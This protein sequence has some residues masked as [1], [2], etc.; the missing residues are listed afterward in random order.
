MILTGGFALW[1]VAVGARY[2]WERRNGT[3]A[4]LSIE[5]AHLFL[6]VLASTYVVFAFD[7]STARPQFSAGSPDSLPGL[8]ID[9]QAYFVLVFVYL[10]LFI[11]WYGSE[12]GRLI[13][14]ALAV[15]VL[16]LSLMFEAFLY[17]PAA[18]PPLALM[19]V[20]LALMRALPWDGEARPVERSI[21]W[22]AAPLLVFSAVALLST[23]LGAFPY[24]SLMVT[25]KMSTMAFVAV[26]VFDTV[27]E[28]RQRWLIW[29]AMTAPT[30]TQAA[31][32]TFKVLD[33]ARVMGLPYAFG[34]RIELA[35]GVDPNPL[36][37]ALAVGILLVAGALPQVRTPA[38]RL[39]AAGALALLLPAL[40]VAYSIPALMGLACGL[41]AMA[42]LYALRCDWRA[43][44]N[45]RTFSAPAIFVAIGLIVMA[46]YALPGTTR[47]GL[48]NTADDPTTGRSRINIWSWAIRDIQ[49]HPILGAGPAYYRGRTRYLP[50]TFPL[51]D[52]TKMLERRRLLGDETGQWHT[53]VTTHPHNLFLAIAE[54]M[55]AVGLIAF[56]IVAAAAVVGAVRIITKRAGDEWWFTAMGLALLVAVAVW[57]MT[58]LGL[59]MA[60]F[61]PAGWLALGYVSLAHRG[62]GART[63]SMPKAIGSTGRR[64]ALALVAATAVLLVCVVRP[65]GSAIA[66][67]VGRDRVADGN[68]AGA[69]TPF[70][71]A[72]WLDPLDVGAPLWLSYTQLQYGKLD[73]GLATMKD[74]NA[75]LPHDPVILTR[76]G[77]VSW[78][79][80]DLSGAEQYYRQAI[81]SDPWQSKGRDAYTP[82]AQLKVSQGKQDEA[83]RILADGFLVNPADVFDAGWIHAADDSSVMLDRVFSQGGDPA[84]N[85]GIRQVLSRSLAL[86][87]IPGDPPVAST[88]SITDVFDA[89]EADARAE[90]THDRG[91][92]IEML[93]QLGVCYRNARLYD[94]AQ[95]VLSDGAALDPQA[96]YI[97]YELAQVDIL[98][99]DDDAAV[100]DL[101]AV[102][103]LAQAAPVYDLR[104]SFAERDLALVANRQKRYAD[105]TTLMLQALDDYRW[106]YL[107]FAYSTLADAYQSLGDAG[108]AAEYRDKE[109]YLTRRG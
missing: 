25:A 109:R 29:L 30:V 50:S 41:I 22:L 79:R 87:Q 15:Q 63:L 78:L 2:A 70:A 91:R 36:G 103:R 10:V 75:R 11:G 53:L 64:R 24:T 54:G 27:R 72:T 12:R 8:Q 46:M 104:L 77:D 42:V 48:A 18:V 73:A 74:A 52:V 82:L 7:L 84:A 40:I 86:Y 85:P 3:A 55:G 33:I 93:H 98:M 96:T 100:A 4:P 101:N 34:N 71:V 94:G 16:L 88:F 47:T 14:T 106:A 60:I 67:K 31:L 20:A 37:L 6:V 62:A 28:S 32:V 89:M 108:K 26:M 97:R 83:T 95:R 9:S 99:K 51:R 66:F 65:V 105:A 5:P 38:L 76:L 58:A 35:A 57:S 90:L 80:G 61:A 39:A 19:A 1:A 17:N 107:P 49:H 102:V 56:A 81:A 21:A 43:W 59:D 44:R 69:E 13:E 23:V 92:G 68:I 45:P